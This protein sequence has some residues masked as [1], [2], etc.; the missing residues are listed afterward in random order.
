MGDLE[1]VI[2]GYYTFRYL[3]EGEEADEKPENIAD[4]DPS[5]LFKVYINP[6]KLTLPEGQ[7][8]I[9]NPNYETHMNFE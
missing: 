9:K 3:K 1:H 4:V 7:E 6:F 2:E 8:F 5:L